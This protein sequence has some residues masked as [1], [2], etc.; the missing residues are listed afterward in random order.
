MLRH[1]LLAQAVQH[2]LGPLEI[3]TDLKGADVFG[4]A[5]AA[6]KAFER[7]HRGHCGPR[8]SST[9][10]PQASCLE[11]LEG[12]L[13]QHAANG[14]PANATQQL[15]PILSLTCRYREQMEH[16]LSAGPEEV[17]SLAFLLGRAVIIGSPAA[18]LVYAE[19]E[20]QDEGSQ[21][22]EQQQQN[23]QEQ[24]QPQQQQHQH[25]Q[26]KQNSGLLPNELAL[27]KLQRDLALLPELAVELHIGPEEAPSL[28]SPS[29]QMTALDVQTVEDL[30]PFMPDDYPLPTDLE[31]SASAQQPNDGSKRSPR[32]SRKRESGAAPESGGGGD[33]LL[34]CAHR[35]SAPV[36]VWLENLRAFCVKPRD[37][38]G[39]DACEVLKLWLLGPG[40]QQGPQSDAESPRSIAALPALIRVAEWNTQK[41]KSTLKIP[42]LDIAL[43]PLHLRPGETDKNEVPLLAGGQVERRSTLYELRFA[44]FCVCR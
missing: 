15:L 22:Q 1:I 3:R 32:N 19:K 23:Q 28:I 18:S 8:E 40:E 44:G 41:P 35:R 6:L 2:F 29:L 4:D 5:V 13:A 31:A 16:W 42:E 10:T 33:Y 30:R 34:D 25:Q 37:P 21:P 7:F 43:E 20:G 17:E 14:G 11:K 39:A 9:P 24:Q 27:Y 36:S 26:Q 38:A 12:S